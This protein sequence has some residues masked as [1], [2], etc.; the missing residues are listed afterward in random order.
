M[1]RAVVEAIDAVAAPPVRNRILELAL[2][3]AGIRAVPDDGPEFRT[4]VEGALC[5]TII[6]VLGEEAALSVHSELALLAEMV[7]ADEVSEVRRSSWPAARRTSS[8]P[9]VTIELGDARPLV[10]TNPAPRDL[11]VLLVASSDPR[12]M[13]HLS[14]AL[15]GV[16]YIEPVTDALEVLEG[17]GRG[18]ASLVVVDCRHP[19]VQAETL[20]AM[21]PELPPD[22]RIVLW[23]EQAALERALTSLPHG[24]PDAWILCGHEASAED[25]AD[26]CRVLL[27]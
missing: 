1:E 24:I 15:S 18:E 17:L 27:E 11:P 8:D 16:A 23:G 20:V 2:K 5:R 3:G 7:P 26:V 12:S 22:S 4:F 9:E 6:Y 19:T 25:V 13:S 10:E 21:Q 14:S